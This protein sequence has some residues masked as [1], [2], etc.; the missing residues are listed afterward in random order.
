MS[1]DVTVHERLVSGSKTIQLETFAGGAMS[2]FNPNKIMACVVP[3]SRYLPVK[4]TS[5][6]FLV[7]SNLYS[8]KVRNHQLSLCIMRVMYRMY[9]S[10]H[11]Q[12]PLDMLMWYNTL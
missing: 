1:L 8:V 7:Q 5:D 12:V 6:L 4:S 3:R 10:M 2:C 9:T 11:V